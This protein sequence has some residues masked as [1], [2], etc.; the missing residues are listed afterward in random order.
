MVWPKKMD[1]I[2]SLANNLFESAMPL[3]R[4][5]ENWP[6]SKKRQRMN[7][8]MAVLWPRIKKTAITVV[9][10]IA[11]FQFEE[12]SALPITDKNAENLK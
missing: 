1:C 2:M 3:G 10:F 9:F 11:G 4:L 6:N 8:R 5:A 7:A 12:K